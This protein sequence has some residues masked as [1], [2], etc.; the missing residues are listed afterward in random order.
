M[1]QRTGVAAAFFALLFTVS[2][3]PAAILINEVMMN[4]PSGND[5]GRE[6]FELI[7]TTG[8]AEALTDLYFIAMEADS[9]STNLGNIDDVINVSSFSTGSNGLFLSREGGSDGDPE[10]DPP[11]APIP[12]IT[13]SPAPDADTVVDL[14]NRTSFDFENDNVTFLLVSGFS[15]SNGDDLDT[16]DD[17][18]LD[19]M[20]WTTVVDAIGVRDDTNAGFEYASQLGFDA[21]P[22]LTSAG[23]TPDTVLRSAGSLDWIAAD[24]EGTGGGPFVFSP[25]E[26]VDIDGN[27]LDLLNDFVDGADLANSVIPSSTPGVTNPALVSDGLLGDF[28]GDMVVDGADYAALRNALASSGTI[29]NDGD[30]GTPDAGDLDDWR[31]AFG[32][33]AGLGAAQS[34]ATPEPASAILLLAAGLLGGARRR[35]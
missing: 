7:S 5:D 23:F 12:P 10:A 14:R 32:A 19:S 24:V 30:D 20:P 28:N 3:A 2:S 35:G 18:V 34:S 1:T 21:F 9:G 17:G 6:Y 4:A 8:G 13:F 11:V 26:L 27:D 33:T 22:V 15:G 29:L 25:L 31:G 16:N